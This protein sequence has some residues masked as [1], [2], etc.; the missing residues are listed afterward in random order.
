MS[1]VDSRRDTVPEHE[2]PGR[3]AEKGRLGPS[4]TCDTEL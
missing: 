3:L 2:S 4:Y 1:T